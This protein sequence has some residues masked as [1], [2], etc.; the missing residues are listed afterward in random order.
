MIGGGCAII[1]AQVKEPSVLFITILKCG[2][3]YILKEKEGNQILIIRKQSC[4]EKNV[5]RHVSYGGGRDST[6]NEGYAGLINQTS[7][8]LSILE[9]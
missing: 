9:G 1:A 7:L 8:S 3:E 4:A 6:H 2:P 5:G